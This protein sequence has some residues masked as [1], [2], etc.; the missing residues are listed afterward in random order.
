MHLISSGYRDII[1]IYWDILTFNLQI[2]IHSS[3]G[4]RNK[5]KGGGLRC[6][7]AIL[8]SPMP[9]AAKLCR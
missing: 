9:C 4:K 1:I 8:K 3:F 2:H 7:I 5:Y 6:L